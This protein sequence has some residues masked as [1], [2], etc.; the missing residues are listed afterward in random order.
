MKKILLGALLIASLGLK[1]QKNT[2]F[3][4]AFWKGNT[5]LATIKAEIEKGNSPSQLNQIS[6]DAT[7]FAISNDAPIESILFLLS[8]PG[9]GVDKLLHDGRTYLFTAASKGNVPVMEYLLKNGA[10]ANLE[11]SHGFSPLTFAAAAGQQNTKVYDLLIAKGADLKK[12]LNHDG[13]NALLIGISND[14]EFALTNYFISKGL[15]LNSVDA[16]GNT[17]F[18]YAAR[19]GNIELMNKLIAKGVKYNDN[20]VLMAAQGGR[21]SSNGLPVF[22][23][24]ESLKLK[25]S[26]LGTNG[27]NALFYIVRK[28]KQEELISYFLS[29]GVDVNQA[30][31]DGNTAFI[32]AAGFTRDLSALELLLKNV[33][34]INQVN[35]K[36]VS[37]LDMAVRSNSA[38]VVKLLLDKGADLKLADKDGN[39]L[40]YYL[41]QGYSPRG[42]ED[43]NAKYKLLTDKGFDLAAAQPNGNSLYHIAVAKNDLA[44]AKF[45]T[46]LK[47][48]VNVK[49][50]EGYTAL[51]KAAM[52]AKDTELMKYL[53][54]VGAKKDV[55]TEFKETPFDLASENEYLSKNKIAIDFLK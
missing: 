10:K 41:M 52:T 8:Q 46:P 22:Q 11:D 23:Y 27:E 53:I 42:M 34:N 44:L 31:K 40:T 45:I 1:A 48:D 30:D 32:N 14:K 9:N 33:K 12:D 49:N 19:T 17:A 3:D 24:L 28:P 5:D 29:K 15:S 18:N 6:F 2:F 13:A 35:A 21:G 4:Q 37:A 47:A 38:D 54:S 20:A 50:K 7:F 43:F 16:S 36:G 25:P 55:T 51:H 39:N 26:A